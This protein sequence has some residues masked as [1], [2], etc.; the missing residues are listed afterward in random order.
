VIVA[1]L[2]RD[3]DSTLH[4]CTCARTVSASAYSVCL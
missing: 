3:G 1:C 4:I 2:D